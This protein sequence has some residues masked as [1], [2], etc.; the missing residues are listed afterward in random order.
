[1]NIET[2][3]EKMYISIVLRTSQKKKAMENPPKYP[4]T[5]NHLKH[6]AEDLRI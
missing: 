3:T 4:D 1:M 6:I 5:I 2:C